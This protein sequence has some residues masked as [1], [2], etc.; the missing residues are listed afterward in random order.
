MKYVTADG[1]TFP[2]VSSG[3]SAGY[4]EGD[5]LAY[6]TNLMCGN[7]TST[8]HHVLVRFA[9]GLDNPSFFR[10]RYL[11]LFGSVLSENRFN[12]SKASNG[13]NAFVAEVKLFSK[14]TGAR[15]VVHNANRTTP[16]HLLSG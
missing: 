1:M 10:P 12:P 4:P 14:L 2:D 9:E 7:E 15:P 11:G 6:L 13:M 16:T 3:F 8:F 5:D